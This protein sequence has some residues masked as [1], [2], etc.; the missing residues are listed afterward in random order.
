MSIPNNIII[1][2]DEK[3]AQLAC[4]I[5]ERETGL[6][7]FMTHPG[8]AYSFQNNCWILADM[9]K[10]GD[11]PDDIKYVIIG[12]G[13][14]STVN[15]TWHVAKA[16]EIKIFDFINEHVP[17]GEKVLVNCCEETPKEFKHLIPKD[18]PGIGNVASEFYD[19]YSYPAKI[20][21]SGRNEIIGAFANG[22]A[23]YY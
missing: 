4:N 22:I 21:E 3:R 20:V 16:P 10:R 5:F 19:S 13:S 1:K 12:H 17:K 15:G 8:E 11:F 7:M 14:G 23:T 18:K 9:I 6:K 2:P